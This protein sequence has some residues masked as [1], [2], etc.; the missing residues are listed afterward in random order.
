[1]AAPN[2]TSKW[3]AEIFER[4]SELNNGIYKQENGKYISASLI[5]TQSNQKPL[6]TSISINI[7][8]V[9]TFFKCMLKHI[10]FSSGKP[11]S[12]SQAAV[13]WQKRQQ[14]HMAIHNEQTDKQYGE[15]LQKKKHSC[16]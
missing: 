11:P 15:K 13:R 10:V 3:P 12:V 1:M 16:K 8:H 14:K 5:A 4:F 6:L 7:V 9:N 2:G